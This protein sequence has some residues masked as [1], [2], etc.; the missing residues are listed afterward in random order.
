MSRFLRA[1]VDSRLAYAL[2]QTERFE[3]FHAANA[4][5]VLKSYVET[6]TQDDILTRIWAALQAH[7]S[8]APADWQAGVVGLELPPLPAS[9]PAAMAFRFA[10]FRHAR[11]EKV[12]LRH[13]VSNHFP[14][15]HL[16]ARL[17]EWKRLIVHPFAAD[18]RL[19]AE[20]LPRHLQ[21]GEWVD[22]DPAL[23]A[24]LSDDLAREGFGPRA[25]TDADDAAFEAAQAAPQG[26][27]LRAPAPAPGP[28]DPN[29]RLQGLQALRQALVGARGLADALR[30]DLALDLDAL[31]LELARPTFARERCL[32]RLESLAA[33]SE[34]Q[35]AAEGLRAAI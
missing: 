18:L 16:N 29:A 25:W 24:C 4:R 7:L 17:M 23:A 21:G 33:Q 11:H 35:Q 10:M 3:A 27:A 2:E 13:F 30:H 6:F 20:R 1:A 12:D 26:A 19:L 15:E 28:L 22:L 34:L 9:P 14:G 31:E 8:L 5:L 32:A